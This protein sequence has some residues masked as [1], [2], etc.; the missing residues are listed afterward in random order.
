MKTKEQIEQRKR[1]DVEFILSA[2]T[3]H[4]DSMVYLEYFSTYENNGGMGWFFD[5]CSEIT[6]KIMFKEG[7]QYLKWL[8]HWIESDDVKSCKVFH[9]I[10]NECF[11][12]YHMIEAQKEFESRYTKDEN[13]DKQ[14][15]SERIGGLLNLMESEEDRVEI[16]L[17]AVAYAKK[18]RDRQL[19]G[20]F[21]SFFSK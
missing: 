16:I 2:V 9:E 17:N 11:D 4:L 12:W 5:E 21:K 6:H 8:D 20:L 7:S 1:K 18:E 15:L 14:N 10:A 3:M 13:I 19:D